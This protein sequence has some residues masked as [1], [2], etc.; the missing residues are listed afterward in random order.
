MSQTVV[1]TGTSKGLGLALANHYL[2]QGATVVGVSRNVSPI[3]ST[4]YF[5][6]AASVTDSDLHR[7][8]ENYLHGLPIRKIDVV[9]NNA[10]SAGS[11][12][13]LSEVDPEDILEQVDLHCVGALRIVKA[14]RTYLD[15]SKVV[16]V[17][18]R[19]GSVSQA[20]RGDFKGR[21]FSYGYRIA[22][23]A[24]NMLSLCL[25]GDPELEGLI[26]ISINPGLLLT[27]CGA[28]DAKQSAE[29]GAENFI[30][31]VNRAATSGMYHAFGDEALF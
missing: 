14:T 20:L 11:G 13:Q 1:I 10:G 17:T 7:R 27:D 15:Q 26:V 18:S 31:V 9:I 30:Q 16:N 4:K 21:N 24:Q 2:D 3:E 5:H 22:K 12:A 8:L 23:C 29:L 19:L 28:S 25:A 6:L